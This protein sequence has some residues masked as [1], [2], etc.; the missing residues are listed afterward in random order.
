MIKVFKYLLLFI[1]INNHLNELNQ[2]QKPHSNAANFLTSFLFSKLRLKSFS[3]RGRYKPVI[4]LLFYKFLIIT[5][6]FLYWYLYPTYYLLFFSSL[7]APNGCALTRKIENKEMRLSAFLLCHLIVILNVLAEK[8]CDKFFH[9]GTKKTLVKFYDSSDSWWVD[10]LRLSENISWQFRN[11]KVGR[12]LS[13]IK[14]RQ[15]IFVQLVKLRKN[16]LNYLF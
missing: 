15:E 9:T 4:V 1:F 10:R 6:L 13:F 2:I 8:Q 16:I 14:I 3:H 11:F 5:D 12:T 7:S